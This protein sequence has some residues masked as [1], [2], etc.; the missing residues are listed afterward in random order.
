[1][2]AQTPLLSLVKPTPGD[3]STSNLW[4]SDINSN[5]DKIDEWASEVEET[6]GGS[7]T[8]STAPPSGGADGDIWYQVPA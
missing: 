5:F 7:V 1:M 2:A 3:P 4:G 6:I 8:I